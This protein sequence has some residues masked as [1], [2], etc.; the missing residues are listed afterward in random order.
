MLRVKYTNPAEQEFLL[1][2]DEFNQGT[3]EPIDEFGITI[4]RASPG[5]LEWKVMNRSSRL[6]WLTPICS[7]FR[8]AGGMIDEERSTLQRLTEAGSWSNLP[9][10][11]K[12]A[13]T[14]IKIQPDEAVVIDGRQWVENAGLS[15]PPGQYR[16]DLVLFLQWVEGG[17]RTLANGRHIFSPVFSVLN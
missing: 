11:C 5:S 16:W 13:S 14:I 6:V 7:S 2:T 4:E 17:Q 15:L 9:V 12:Q 1:Y 8:L 10:A 3:P